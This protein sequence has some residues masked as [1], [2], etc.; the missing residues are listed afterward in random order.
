MPIFWKVATKARICIILSAAALLAA[1]LA[2]LLFAAALSDEIFTL[3]TA[4]RPW[5]DLWACLQADVHPPL[6]YLLVKAWFTLT[7]PGLV[8]LRTLSL[9]MAVAAVC[10]AGWMIPA[11]P[12]LAPWAA[13]FFAADGIL[14]MMAAYGRMYT[15]LALLCLLAWLASDR[16]LRNARPGWAVLAGAAIA[17]GLCTH[18]F[19]GLFLVGLAAW[20]V[21]VHQR[22]SVR[23]AIP[24]T[25]GIAVW[26]AFWGRTAWDQV[27]NRTAH[28]AWVPP[29]DFASWALIAASHLVFVLAALPI[30][31]IALG[32]SRRPAAP[33]WPPEARAAAAAALLTLALPGILSLWRPLLNARFTI[34]AAPFLAVALAPLGRW[35]SGV[36]P[37]AAFALASIW[38]WWP[39]T[40]AE[41]NSREAAR[42]LAARASAH[43]T[44]LFCRLTRKPIEYHWPAPAPQRRSFPAEIDT[45][46]GYE[47]RQTTQQLEAEAHTLAA[48]LTRRVFV[49]A[50]TDNPSCQ[51]LLR[52]LQAAGWRQRETL[53]ACPGV[54]NHYFNRLLLFE[55][56]LTRAV[57]PSAA[58]PGPG[59]PPPGPD[60]RA[61]GRP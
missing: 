24:W 43:D 17:A 26:A 42:M 14:L 40:G 34:I 23:L 10:V 59:S 47:G 19:F 12:V 29:T 2:P 8:S 5:P 33:S 4:S 51:T 49:L 3:E 39:H 15:L 16:W 27:T 7:G 25:A 6:H 46:P 28:L 13:W 45:H 55:P 31:L 41:C 1:V 37:G 61:Y 30:A 38:L 58:P 54:R 11:S 57:S 32:W 50:D 35:T 44:V 56:P 48:S 36:L 53:L 9:L 52:V 22:A 18:H 21:I 20:S 60:V